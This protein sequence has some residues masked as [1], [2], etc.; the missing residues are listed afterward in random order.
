MKTNSQ[1]ELREDWA[2]FVRTEM[3]KQK[4]ENAEKVIGD[5]WID[6]L[7]SERKKIE[8]EIERR[9]PLAMGKC[10]ENGSDMITQYVDGFNACLSLVKELLNK[11][12]QL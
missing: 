9:L 7:T 4:P 1:E 11:I 8:E 10:R 2:K 12:K 6:K 5:W 3:I